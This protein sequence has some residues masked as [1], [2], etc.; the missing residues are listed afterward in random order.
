[1]NEIRPGTVTLIGSGEFSDSMARIY[2]QLLSR[3]EPGSDAAFLDTPAGFELNSGEIYTRA[4]KYF[5]RFLQTPLALASFRSKDQATALQV[6]MAVRALQSAGLIF[7]GPGSPTYAVRNL[8]DTPLWETITSNLKQNL[9]LVLASAAAVAASRYALPVYEIYKVGAPVQWTEGLDL[10]GPWG[11]NLAIIPHWNNSEGGTY[12]TRFCYM[13]E[14]RLR[15]LEAQLPG[16]A[17]ILGI[18]EYTACAL[19]L[20]AQ[21][22][23]VWGAGRVTVRSSGREWAFG[24]G[25]V[26]SF[27]RLRAAN[28]SPDGAAAGT[29]AGLPALEPEVDAQIAGA[30]RYLTVLAQALEESDDPGSYRDLVERAHATVHEL[31]LDWQSAEAAGPAADLSPLLDLLLWIRAE[32]RRMGQFALADRIR[33]RLAEQGYIVQDTT[34]GPRWQK[35]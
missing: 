3:M 4:D 35:S 2:R 24:A 9:Q 7:A 34:T 6:E 31:E 21:T 29:G 13:G 25:E 22:A 20:A 5:A 10:L 15:E 11:L 1:M 17:V 14:S 28:L 16:D 30:T 26:I 33:D 8:R 32:L 19:D 12:D 18:D 27:A 23:Q